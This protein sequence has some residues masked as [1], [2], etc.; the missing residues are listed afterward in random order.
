MAVKLQLRNRLDLAQDVLGQGLDGAA[1]PGRLAGE[2]LGVDLVEG[3][4]VG[5]VG[6][7]A[8]GLDDLGQVGAGGGQDG[9]HIAA[10]LLGLGGDALGDI[11]GG[12]IHGDLAGAENEGTC[13]HALGVGADG[14]RGVG[15]G[16][17]GHGEFLRFLK[18][19]A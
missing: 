1:A 12:R 3:G 15:G 19:I 13:D 4:E 11:A 5:H 9:G 16:D 14:G 2:V 18:S 8:G 6:D 7:E 10:A 17:D